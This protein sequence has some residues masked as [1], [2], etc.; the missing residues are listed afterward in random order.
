MFCFGEF[1]WKQVSGLFDGSVFFFGGSET[2]ALVFTRMQ[3]L[4]VGHTSTSAVL[5]RS[6]HVC[7]FT[8]TLSFACIFMFFVF[9]Q[10]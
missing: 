6:A 10:T 8:Y 1:E 7:M 2:A 9:S 5:T 4:C 3:S